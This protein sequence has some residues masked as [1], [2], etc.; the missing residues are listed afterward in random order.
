MSLKLQY[1]TRGL[2][3][4]DFKKRGVCLSRHKARPRPFQLID[5]QVLIL[6]SFLLI[7]LRNMLQNNN[8]QLA[9]IKP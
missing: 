2:A 7:T 4:V 9:A 3:A 8:F 6:I 1:I 5:A